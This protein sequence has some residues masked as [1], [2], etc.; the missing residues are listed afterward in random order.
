[1]TDIT[2]SNPIPYTMHPLIESAY[3][4]V[5]NQFDQDAGWQGYRQWDEKDSSK[6]LA[7]KTPV[8][9]AFNFHYYFPTH[10][11]KA[12]HAL[13]F[14][15]IVG[16][17]KLAGWLRYNP[18]LTVVDIGCGDGA[19]SVAVI[20]SVIRLREM[21]LIDP[22][23]IQIHCIGVDHN[24]HGLAIY[25]AMMKETA[26]N[27]RTIDICV[28]YKV[29]PST[30]NEAIGS[31]E[32][33]LRDVRIQWQQPSLSH[34]IAIAANVNDLLNADER[35]AKQKLK[36]AKPLKSHTIEPFGQQLASFHYHLFELVPIDH[37]HVITVD[38]EPQ[39]IQTVVGEMLQQ[40]KRRFDQQAHGV[41]DAHTRL[42]RITF[43]NPSGSFWR[44]RKNKEYP[45]KPFKPY[46]TSTIHIHNRQLAHDAR[47]Q[48]IK[49]KENLEL[50]W[51]RARREMLREAFSDETELRIFEH[52]LASNLERLHHELEAYA[53]RAGY[54]RQTLRYDTPKDSGNARPK[55][56]TW[57]EEEI[58]IIAIIQ[59]IGTRWLQQIPW[60]YAYRLS[61]DNS[62]ERG[63]TE[64]LYE[65]WSKAWKDY[66]QGIA[67]YAGAH[68]DGVIIKMD[69]KSYFTR[70]LQDRL[71][72]IIKHELEVS[73][74]IEW[75]VEHLVSKD[76]AGHDPGK[77]LVQ[78]STGSGFLANLYLSAVDYLF[79]PNDA[80]GRRLFRYVDDIVVVVPNAND[81]KTTTELLFTIIRDDLHLE[82][83]V[84]K[85]SCIPIK[86]FLPQIASDDALDKSH[87]AYE[88]LL[89][90]LWRMDE[91][92]RGRFK[93]ASADE[94]TWWTHV[95]NYRSC[96]IE[97]GI[98]IPQA[99]LSRKLLPEISN[100]DVSQ[101]NISFPTLPFSISVIAT[102]QW[103]K[104]FRTMN[105]EWIQKLSQYKSTLIEIF[106]E[107]LAMV[108][109]ASE[110]A[111]NPAIAEAGRRMRF[112]AN[113]LGILGLDSIHVDLTEFLCKKPWLIRYQQLLLENLAV[114]GYSDDVWRIVDFHQNA[115]SPMSSYMSA[116]AIR[117][118]RFLPRLTPVEWQRLTDFMFSGSELVMLTATE[119]WLAATSHWAFAYLFSILIERNYRI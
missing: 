7:R 64:Y 20:E 14:E 86:Q 55:G 47:W 41:E 29:Y 4:A 46:I 10:Y 8:A 21:K 39:K 93:N 94:T 34:T 43:K 98:F 54:L 12:R 95:A 74:R 119:T 82:I 9:A 92:A 73:T 118:L 18:Y 52:N 70:I 44:E 40:V 49:S 5:H 113:R 117:A 50:A 24:P 66:R 71:K 104:K 78:G 28:T 89:T 35:E 112:T 25:E 107:N 6:A 88:A 80:K 3:Q 23:A 103:A 31:V 15:D 115:A 116:I 56:L 108:G 13:E 97:L 2:A 19:G 62:P 102:R 11:F 58:L 99:W 77:G 96:L 91:G 57:L 63:V 1:M 37:L 51:A 69:I 90:P 72:E 111:D 81:E 100:E 101:Q 17:D 16:L 114:Q 60:S 106:V 61:P 42:D 33:A 85:S 87:E 45:I 32:M 79:L 22:R 53:I 65:A 109:S 83:N 26:K 38:T 110:D 76:L 48:R 59:V 27:G 67:A 30:I 75:L 84:K 68:P 36:A 105:P